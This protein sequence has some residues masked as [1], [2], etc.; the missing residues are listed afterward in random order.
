ME[1][2]RILRII[3]FGLVLAA[4]TIGYLIFSGKF[5][6]PQTP[7]VNKTQQVQTSEAVAL[8]PTFSP[9]PVPSP[10]PEGTATQSAYERIMERN[11]NQAQNKVT[12][13]PKTGIPTTLLGLISLSAIISGW[14]LRKYP[15]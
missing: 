15:R 3:L 5:I 1:D 8:N 12:T 11:K 14:T 13:L 2:P 9:T 7:T 10:T 6:K 4:L